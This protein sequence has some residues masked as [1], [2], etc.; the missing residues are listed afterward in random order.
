MAPVRRFFGE[1]LKEKYNIPMI[2]LTYY[3]DKEKHI[4]QFVDINEM[5][6]NKE[7]FISDRYIISDK[8][9]SVIYR[10]GNTIDGYE[11]LFE[12]MMNNENIILVFALPHD[13]ERYL[14]E[15]KRLCNMREEMYSDS[16]DKVYDKYVEIY[17]ELINKNNKATIIRYDRFN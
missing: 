2:H 15:F 12:N 6:N 9:Y 16:M 1:Q 8:V 11:T 10:N 13:K 17:E 4:K 7:L 3:T 5:I 14:N